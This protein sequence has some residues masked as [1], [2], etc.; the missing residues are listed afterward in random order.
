MRTV[1]LILK[2]RGGEALDREEIRYLISGYVQEAIPDYQMAAFLMAVCFQGMSREE[3]LE[4][5]LAMLAS[6]D[7]ISLGDIPGVKVD[8]HSTGGVGDTTTLVL[9]PL[10]AA[11]GVPVAKMSGRGLGHTGGTL[12]K[13]ASIPGFRTDLSQEEMVAAVK[14]CGV[15]VVGQT[16]RLVPADR[17]MY[18]LRDVTG[19][20][21]SLPLIAG[22]IMSKKL[23]SGADAL[24]LDVKAGDGAF[25]QE[26]EEAFALART[27][28][29]I[30]EGAGVRTAALIT[31]MEEPL[32]RAVGNALEMEEAILTLQ[33]EG[34]R[35]LVELCLELGGT[36]LAVAG[37]APDAIAGREI[38]QELLDRGAALNKLRELI[39]SQQGDP[40]VLEDLS[41]LPRAEKTIPFTWPEGGYVRKIRAKRVG[42]CAML[43]GAG[44]ETRDSKIDL[45]AGILLKKKVGDPVAAGEELA[46][47][48]A[49]Q[50]I[51]S[52]RLTEAIEFLKGA[53]EI[54][55]EKPPVPRLILGKRGN[56]TAKS[57]RHPR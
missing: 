11:A 8:K 55:P 44:R 51:K 39:I 6:G 37:R 57:P 19:T 38:L 5:T 3:T 46:L 18:A 13:F 36:M 23:A 34:P 40:R 25:L 53:Y 16:G 32:G 14:K 7:R 48:H 12:D 20:V 42:H 17:K 50:R 27:M 15:A 33:G 47:L 35:D 21:Q 22:S 9:A 30:G 28:V 52:G 56:A 26:E 24:V 4:L 31:G 1:D 43:L 54:G 41:L 45:G 10:V 49:G 2:K 29:E